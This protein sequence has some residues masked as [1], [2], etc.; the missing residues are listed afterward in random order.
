MMTRNLHGS[1]MVA[2]LLLAGCMSTA[3]HQVYP[4]AALPPEETCVLTVPALLD[5]VAIDGVQM[6]RML[7]LKTGSEQRLSLLP[8]NHLLQVRY[9][10]PTADESRHELYMAGPVVV[11]FKAAAKGS[12]ALQFETSL[13]NPALKRTPDKFRA[14]VNDGSP[15]SETTAPSLGPAP[16]VPTTPAKSVLLDR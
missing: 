14:W 11:R 13:Q 16:L 12:Y 5:V 8:G 7:R 15:A 6:D 3:V 10:D 4:G 2:L 9:Y 1:L